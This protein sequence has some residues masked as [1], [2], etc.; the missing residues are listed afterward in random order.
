MAARMVLLP[1]RSLPLVPHTH[2]PGEWAVLQ[3]VPIGAGQPLRTVPR[4][5]EFRLNG[6]LRYQQRTARSTS[7]HGAP[8]RFGDALPNGPDALSGARSIAAP[9]W[10]GH[11]RPEGHC[12][13]KAKSVDCVRIVHWMRNSLAFV[14]WNDRKLIM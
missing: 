9:P 3:Q 2:S 12:G 8:P 4:A 5:D 13:R 1:H 14:S 10:L 6:P 11:R 7:G